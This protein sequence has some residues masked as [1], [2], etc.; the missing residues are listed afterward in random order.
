MPPKIASRRES[1]G[2][3]F[4]ARKQN[5]LPRHPEPAEGSLLEYRLSVIPSLSRDLYG[6][7]DKIRIE[8]LRLR[9]PAGGSAQDDKEERP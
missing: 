6:N 8:I 4:P 5:R 3:I 9:R 2:Q 1:R 7:I